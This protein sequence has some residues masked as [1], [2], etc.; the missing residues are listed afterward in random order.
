MRQSVIDT[1]ENTLPGHDQTQ[2]EYAEDPVPVFTYKRHTVAQNGATGPVSFHSNLCPK[3][4][5][6]LYPWLTDQA[7]SE[8]VFSQIQDREDLLIVSYKDCTLRLL[9]NCKL[10]AKYQFSK[11]NRTEITEFI[12]HRNDLLKKL[13]FNARELAPRFNG[14]GTLSI[15]ATRVG[16]YTTQISSVGLD[17]LAEHCREGTHF[18]K[19]TDVGAFR[20]RIKTQTG[21]ETKVQ[22]LKTG[23]VLERC[24]LSTTDATSSACQSVLKMQLVPILAAGPMPDSAP[25]HLLKQ[26]PGSERGR[27]LETDHMGQTI[28]LPSPGKVTVI[29]FLHPAQNTCNEALTALEEIWQRADKSKA[30]I[31]AVATGTTIPKARQQLSTLAVT[32]P[33]VIDDSARLTKR[34]LVGSKKPSVVILDQNGYMQF[35]SD[36]TS[37]YLQKAE[38][39]LR[40][41]TEK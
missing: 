37:G 39:A 40:A 7:L 32:F 4:S 36:G 41:L 20:L 26:L 11:A 25:H 29:A 30:Q 1:P 31:V 14:T 33:L 38:A 34:Y 9:A 5:E 24:L 27:R 8:Q 13:P 15:K 22:I 18:V 28:P 35:Y 19:Q 23:G 2:S 3:K 10:P 21:D 12:L 6:P 16:Y 17:Q